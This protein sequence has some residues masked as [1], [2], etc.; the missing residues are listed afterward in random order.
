MINEYDKV[1]NRELLDMCLEHFNEPCIFHHEIARVIGYGETAIDCYIIALHPE[2]PDGKV[3][4]HTCVGGYYFL[5]RLKGQG[6]VKS[7]GGEDWDDLTRLNSSLSLNGAPKQDKFRLDLDH[8]N[9]EL[10]WFRER[11][12]D[13]E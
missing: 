2:Y 1:H 9:E 13:D 6:Y 4:W 11:S 3:V 12:P 7:T 10:Q 8:G 5:D